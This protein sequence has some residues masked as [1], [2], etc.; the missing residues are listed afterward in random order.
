MTSLRR[1]PSSTI[2]I[3][4]RGMFLKREKSPPVITSYV[5]NTTCLTFQLM[6]GTVEEDSRFQTFGFAFHLFS[7]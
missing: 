7:V 4:H 3:S 1:C 6:T 2:N 5:V